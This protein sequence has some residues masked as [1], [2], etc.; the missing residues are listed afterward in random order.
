V[1]LVEETTKA[2]VTELYD[3]IVP[4]NLCV[5]SLAMIMVCPIVYAKPVPPVK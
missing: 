1:L 4:S 5:K 3:D 2:P